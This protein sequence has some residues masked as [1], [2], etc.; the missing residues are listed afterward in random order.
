M[1]INE[2]AREAFKKHDVKE[3]Y[4]WDQIAAYIDAG[5]VKAEDYN[6]GDIAEMF[7]HLF[8]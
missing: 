2:M 7:K 4:A 8:F 1:T 5:T 6:S 3:S